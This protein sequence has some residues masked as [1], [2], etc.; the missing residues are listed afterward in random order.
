MLVSARWDHHS[1]GQSGR[2]R[3]AVPAAAQVVL[4][5]AGQDTAAPVLKAT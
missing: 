3:H 4:D 5:T 1:A 2:S